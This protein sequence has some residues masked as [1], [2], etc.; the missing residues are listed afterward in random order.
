MRLAILFY[1]FVLT[2]WAGVYQD[3]EGRF[4]LEVPNG[5]ATKAAGANV[6]FVSGKA[7]AMATVAGS[8]EGVMA[9]FG[10]Q[11]KGLRKLPGGAN[12]Y[13]GVNPSGVEA[14]VK[15]V[16]R[17]SV[18]LLLSAPA[19]EWGGRQGEMGRMEGSLRVGGGRT[20]AGAGLMVVSRAGRVGQAMAGPGS[21]GGSARQAFRGFYG[22]MGRYFDG[23]VRVVSALADA[24]DSEVQAFFRATREGVPVRG[25]V[26]V[27]KAKVGMAF[28]EESQFGRSIGQLVGS[29]GGGPEASPAQGAR[30]ALGPLQQQ[31]FPDGSGSIGVPQG[32]RLANALNGVVDMAGP[33]GAEAAFGYYQQVMVDWPGARPNL[34]G[35]MTGPPRDPATALRN[36]Y[37]SNFGGAISGG[38][39][40][41]R[42]VEGTPIQPLAGGQASMLLVEVRSAQGSARAL[43]LVSVSPVGGDRWVFYMSQVAAPIDEFAAQLPV[44]LQM[45]ASWSLNPAL[46]RERMN[47][48]LRSMRETTAILQGINDNQRRAGERGTW[49]WSKTIGGVQTVEDTATGRRGDVDMNSADR[50]VQ[51]LNEQGYSYRVVPVKELV[52]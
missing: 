42:V 33:R 52:P 7:Y 40:T 51:G 49:G 45:W 9:E 14:V 2:I 21:G 3:P 34:K 29:L 24:Q 31:R 5:W 22:T 16:S 48:A 30:L 19:A 43:A 38:L 4:S 15:A 41:Y 28:D 25:W 11:W 12:V 17:G 18:V 44:M 8:V 6:Y 20:A 36:Y 39:A 10:R 27:S 50:I 35:F 13:A 1:G 32:W 23:P 26:V 47:N 46:L 37:D